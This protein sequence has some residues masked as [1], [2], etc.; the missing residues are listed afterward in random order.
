M[1]DH[2]LAQVAPP[3]FDP[4]ALEDYTFQ[5]ITHIEEALLRQR[6]AYQLPLVDCDPG[7]ETDTRGVI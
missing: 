5:G 4:K 1:L 6:L 7:D 3:V 2:L